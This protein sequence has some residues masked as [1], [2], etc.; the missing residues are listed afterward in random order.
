MA[1]VSRGD[2][3]RGVSTVVGY[4]LNIG[5]ATLLITGLIFGAGDLVADQRE[6]AV[7][8]EFDVIGNRIA[9]DLETADRLVQASNGGQV[10]VHSSL[11]TFISGQQYLVSVNETG[12]GVNVVL[13]MDRPDVTVR[14]PVNNTTAVAETTVTGGDLTIN[15]T[16][17]GPLEV[18]DG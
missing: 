12:T 6:R 10:S 17:N 11:P 15:A 8:S 3:D 2:A 9:A 5:I 7:R 14:V 16:G 13:T 18:R 1:D 4:V